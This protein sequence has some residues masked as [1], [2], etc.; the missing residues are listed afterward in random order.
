M[1]SLGKKESAD[2]KG[3]TVSIA[4]FA[5]RSG[6]FLGGVVNAFLGERGGRGGG[7]G[8]DA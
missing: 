5:S 8:R 4:A 3:G 6:F 7:K 2:T 1:Y